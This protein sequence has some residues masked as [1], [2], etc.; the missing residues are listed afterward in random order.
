MMQVE[1]THRF[2]ELQSSPDAL[3]CASQRVEDGR[4]ICNHLSE[5]MMMYSKIEQ[6]YAKSLKDLLQSGAAR[7]E[8]APFFFGLFGNAQKNTELHSLL[9]SFESIK[10]QMETLVGAHEGFSHSLRTDV[11]EPLANH[12][13]SNEGRKRRVFSEA[14]ELDTQYRKEETL[15]IRERNRYFDLSHRAMEQEN[16]YN[17][18]REAGKLKDLQKLRDLRDKIGAVANE[19]ETQEQ[20]YKR[21]VEHMQ[22]FHRAKLKDKVGAVLGDLESLEES[23]VSQV[24]DVLDVFTQSVVQVTAAS[25]LVGK[26]IVNTTTEVDIEAD[27]SEW[28][29]SATGKV[30]RSRIAAGPVVFEPFDSSRTWTG[31]PSRSRQSTS[32]SS[33]LSGTTSQ[34]QQDAAEEKTGA[35][36]VVKAI[37]KGEPRPVTTAQEDQMHEVDISTPKKREQNRPPQPVQQ[38]QQRPAATQNQAPTR[39]PRANPPPSALDNRLHTEP[40]PADDMDDIFDTFPSKAKGRRVRKKKPAQQEE[41]AVVVAVEEVVME[42]DPEEELQ[43]LTIDSLNSKLLDFVRIGDYYSHLGLTPAA[44]LASLQDALRSA[45]GVA[46]VDDMRMVFQGQETRALYDKLCEYRS[47][48]ETL[49]QQLSLV[50]D[51][52]VSY[53]LTNMTALKE[54]FVDQAMPRALIQEIDAVLMVMDRCSK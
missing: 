8:S 44:D 15:V 26:A 10:A 45:T 37:P 23:R 34:R 40:A 49:A 47:G 7:F 33:S 43:H 4:A 14:K 21:Q 20:K 51:D 54:A 19:A 1:G 36:L 25:T 50:S 11:S 16:F 12:L 41:P 18:V 52:M 38:Q 17:R 35:A 46:C 13:K 29:A 30:D 9:K 42:T 27:L 31:A 2:S 39:Q 28:V 22:R 32:R 48:Y 24:K 3:Y 5:F 53:A 6:R